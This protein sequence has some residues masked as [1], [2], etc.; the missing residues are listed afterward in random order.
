MTAIDPVPQVPKTASPSLSL[1]WMQPLLQA[2][3]Q[4]APAEEAEPLAATASPDAVHYVMCGL[5]SGTVT[6][7]TDFLSAVA[8]ARKLVASGARRVVF[9]TYGDTQDGQLFKS[10]R[11]F[12]LHV[13][14]ALTARPA[15]FAVIPIRRPDHDQ[16][17]KAIMPKAP[18]LEDWTTARFI[19]SA[20]SEL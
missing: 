19:S 15:E 17:G 13:S 1:A 16:N 12:S 6:A 14:R 8:K 4:L 11:S 9:L 7:G 2:G 10:L 5:G 20:P 18:S 3:A